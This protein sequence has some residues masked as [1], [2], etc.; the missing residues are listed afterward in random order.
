PNFK[1]FVCLLRKIRVMDSRLR[2]GERLLYSNAGWGSLFLI[3]A[4]SLLISL[5]ASAF[6]VQ[7]FGKIQNRVKNRKSGNYL[8]N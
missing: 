5:S 4:R 7:I 1:Y 3:Y 2:G 6:G 8:A